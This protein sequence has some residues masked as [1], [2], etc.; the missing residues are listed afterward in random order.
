[1]S[2]YAIHVNMHR[3]ETSGSFLTPEVVERL[4]TLG[5]VSWQD[6]LES[7]DSKEAA[8][9]LAEVQAVVTGWGQTP[10]TDEVLDLMPQLEIIA[11]TAGSVGA[12]V[13]DPV[14]ARGIRVVSGNNVF[15]MSVAEAVLA[16]ILAIYRR[17]PHYDARMKAGEW[18]TALDNEGLFDR[19]VALV[20]FGAI[21]RYLIPM[22]APF[23]CQIEA[24]D[25]YVSE[26]EMA[27]YGVKKIDLP[28]CFHEQDIVSL[29]LPLT[30]ETVNL[31]DTAMLKRMK[32]G[33]V[34]INTARGGV[35]D[36]SALVKALQE[37]RIRAVLDV[38]TQEPLDP[39]SP[40]RACENA[41]LIPHMAG[42]TLDRRPA[43]A[44]AVIDDIERLQQG[45]ELQHEISPEKAARMTRLVK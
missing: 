32:L 6:E 23:N 42:P 18:R 25:P 43:A 24:Y 10:F 26:E 35:I 36:E 4:H 12:F 21:P 5:R 9:T 8:A 38:F 44:H 15:A 41:I 2:K 33:A 37:K 40:L 29:H 45:L 7:L 1:M 28:A 3:N 11:H 27:A 34:L 30:P 16:Y 13:G 20:G 39:N 19:K 14:Y 31:V 22:L 17:I